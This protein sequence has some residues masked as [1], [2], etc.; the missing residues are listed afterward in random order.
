MELL[1]SRGPIQGS[2]DMV[3]NQ[4]IV[5]VSGM[6]KLKASP[7]FTLTLAL[8]LAFSADLPTELTA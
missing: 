7:V 4:G 3:K 2:K 8:A 5:F 6:G 1:N